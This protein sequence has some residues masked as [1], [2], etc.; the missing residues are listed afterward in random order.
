MAKLYIPEITA[1][2]YPAFRQMMLRSL[3]P[4]FKKWQSKSRQWASDSHAE[5]VLV[6]P[7][8]FARY[9][10]QAKAKPSLQTLRDF[11][12]VVGAGTWRR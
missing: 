12:Y 9:C 5:R 7:T 4:T 11:A 1:A 2:D 6:E 3:P 10:L 8:K